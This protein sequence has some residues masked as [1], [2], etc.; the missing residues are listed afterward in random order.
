M[1]NAEPTNGTARRDAGFG[2]DSQT[3]ES[4]L[5]A[6]GEL[7]GSRG[8]H[9]VTVDDIRRAA[10]VSRA[11]FYF[12]FRNKSHIFMKLSDSVMNEMYE[13]AGQHY[14]EKD[15]YSRIILANIAYLSVWARRT[16]IIGEF[17]AL[18]LVDGE[19]RE[20]YSRH[21]RRFEDRI[22]GR[23]SRLVESNRIPP[24]DPVLLAAALSSMVEFFAFRFFATHEEISVERYSFNDAVALL[25]ESWYRAVYGRT[26]PFRVEDA[27]AEGMI[28]SC[29]PAAVSASS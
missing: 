26:P 14:P 12:Y 3:Y 28:E 11:T 24:C 4:L 6:A 17:F 27:L 2:A 7:I 19:I 8:Y 18:S 9:D 13:V 22:A 1:I 15:E 23:L 29:S 5:R 16:K 25:S 20:I 10:G 21:R